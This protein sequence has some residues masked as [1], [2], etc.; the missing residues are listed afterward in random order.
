MT[1]KNTQVEKKESADKVE[2]TRDLPVYAPETDI[3]E[4]NDS[5]LVVCD[6]P[7]VDEQ[8]VDITLEDDVLTLT[9]CQKPVDRPGYSLLYRGYGTGIFRRSFTLSADIDR[10][11]IKARLA[12][13]VLNVTLPK[14]AK[15]QPRKIAVEAGA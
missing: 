14:A 8:S 7:G 1:E 12:N 6:M 5:I 9:G 2:M 15:A 11:S 13:G 4:K 3:F 10:D